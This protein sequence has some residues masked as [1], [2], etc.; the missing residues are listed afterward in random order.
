M[1]RIHALAAALLLAIAAYASP[2]NADIKASQFKLQNG[3]QVVVIPDHRAPVVTHMLWY[4]VG[5]TDDPQGHSG[6][7]HFFEHLMFKGTKTVPPG[8]L[9]KIVARNGGQDN[10]F[11]SYD[12]TA[13]FER[14]AKDRLPLVMQLEADRMVN[15]DLSEKN[16]RTERDVVLEERRTRIESDPSAQLQEQMNAALNP[17]NPYGRPVIGWANEIAL[18]ERPAALDFYMHH[19]APNNAILV[20]AGDVQPKEAQA[21]AQAKYGA[22]APRKLAE[23]ASIAEVPR[24]KASRITMTLADV[25]LPMFMRIYRVPSYGQAKPGV[26]ESLELLAEIM[27][28]GSNSRLYQSLVVKKQIATGAGAWYGGYSRGSTQ[29]GVLAYPRDG[30]SLDQLEEATDEVIREMIAS[31]PDKEEFERAKTK[32]MADA[33]Y[34][35]D[36][37]STMANA[38]GSAL[39]I[40]L[41]T[42]DVEE[43]PKRIEAVAAADVRKA[44]EDH[45]RKEESVT[46]YL[47]PKPAP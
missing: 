15:L 24:K 5:G 21:L 10:A 1:L 2:A 47:L 42:K 12:Y 46:G 41:S 45:L 40:G 11:T 32:T 4:R 22:V 39:A 27:G 9:S 34:S 37:Q 17:G 31:P 29:F 28:G 20:L 14:I 38:Y 6:L 23:R 8:E 30:V 26:A 13:F 19:Y 35:R 3:M 36:S 16:V 25:R 44:A 18:I 43:W 33:I 7:A